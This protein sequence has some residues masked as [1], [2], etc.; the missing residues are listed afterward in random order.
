MPTLEAS[1]F[2]DRLPTQIE[3]DDAKRFLNILEKSRRPSGAYTFFFREIG[4]HDAPAEVHLDKSLAEVLR[5]LLAIIAHGQAVQITPIRAELSTLQAAKALGVSRPYLI[6]LLERGEI[7]F[8]NVGRHRRIKAEDVFDYKR[9][10]DA[11]RSKVLAEMLRDD[12][13]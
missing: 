6:K 4:S 2:G 3:Q 9:G 10:Q 8:R 1:G 12:G 7:P 11:V 5:Q 13:L